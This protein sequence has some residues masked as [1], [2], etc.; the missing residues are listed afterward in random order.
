MLFKICLARKKNRTCINRTGARVPYYG[1]GAIIS[2]YVRTLGESSE[3]L[4]HQVDTLE[5]K[6]SVKTVAIIYVR[7]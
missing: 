6:I 2:T 1:I 5:Q 7:T 4:L 3:S